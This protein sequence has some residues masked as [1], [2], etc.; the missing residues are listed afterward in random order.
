MKAKSTDKQKKITVLILSALLAL[1]AIFRYPALPDAPLPR[2]A[3]LAVLLVLL[4][5]YNIYL[6]FFRSREEPFSG[7]TLVLFFLLFAAAVILSFV[8]QRY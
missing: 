1:L 4:A 5:G 3:L 8:N 2:P 7:R 6:F